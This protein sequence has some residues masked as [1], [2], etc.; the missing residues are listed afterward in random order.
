MPEIWGGVGYNRSAALPW[1]QPRTVASPFLDSG[2]STCIHFSP[3]RRSNIH[4]NDKG[5]VNG[6]LGND[7]RQQAKDRHREH[8][9][10]HIWESRLP[11][12]WHEGPSSSIPEHPKISLP[13]SVIIRNCAWVWA[14]V[15]YPS[16]SFL[17]FRNCGLEAV[18]PNM[19]NT[20]LSR[21]KPLAHAGTIICL[22]NSNRNSNRF[23]CTY[24]MILYWIVMKNK[25]SELTRLYWVGIPLNQFEMFEERFKLLSIWKQCGFKFETSVVWKPWINSEKSKS[26]D[27]KI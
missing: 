10:I 21:S 6:Y 19:G 25:S 1:F 17:G 2:C 26:L 13:S 7:N 22:E 18:T 8:Q 12:L 5:Q 15:M 14:H 9:L 24:I 11:L 3:T 4:A 23:V 16:E 20:K 27:L